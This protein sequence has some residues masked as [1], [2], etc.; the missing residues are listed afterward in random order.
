MTIKQLKEFI[1]SNKLLEANNVLWEYSTVPKTN[2]ISSQ[3]ISQIDLDSLNNKLNKS[4]DKFRF[5]VKKDIGIDQS[6]IDNINILRYYPLV[7]HI[8]YKIQY[9]IKEKIK[10]KTTNLRLTHSYRNGKWILTLIINEI[11]IGEVKT[12]CSLDEMLSS[13]THFGAFPVYLNIRFYYNSNKNI[14]LFPIIGIQFI[15]KSSKIITAFEHS[16][17]TAALFFPSCPKGYYTTCPACYALNPFFSRNCMSCNNMIKNEE[18][19]SYDE[20]IDSYNKLLNSNKTIIEDQEKKLV[21]QNEYK[22]K[23]NRLKGL[24]RIFLVSIISVIF[25]AIVIVVSVFMKSNSEIQKVNDQFEQIKRPK[26]TFYLDKYS[27]NVAAG[28]MAYIKIRGEPNTMY[29]ISVMYSS[30]FSDA[31]GLTKKQSNDKGEISWEWKVGNRTES[32]KYPISITDGNNK[33]VVY[34]YVE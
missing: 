4:K 20:I 7:N 22:I 14:I 30:G 2:S 28:E 3:M 26:H 21:S 5:V 11:Q 25:L 32:G 16:S 24:N 15:G 33:I 13:E 29:T 10:K 23:Y 8:S 1:V 6:E 19:K 18:G 17:E 27:Q 34:F 12:D 9:E 31:M